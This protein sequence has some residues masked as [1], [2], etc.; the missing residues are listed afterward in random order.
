M[1]IK[2]KFQN[3]EK[4]IDSIFWDRDSYFI[5]FNQYWA[6]IAGSVA[7]KFAENNSSNWGQFDL[8]RTS[9]IKILG[10]NPDN[11]D[12]HCSAPV[13]ILSVNN[14]PYIITGGLFYLIKDK[15]PDEV[16][17]LSQ[18]IVSIALKE[19]REYLKN[20]I[21]TN[22][23]ERIKQI[24]HSVLHS[25][26]TNDLKENTSAFLESSR[27]SN[28]ITNLISETD[29]H[30]LEAL[31]NN[32]AYLVTSN[33]FLQE[34][35][36][37]KNIKNVLLI[38]NLNEMSFESISNNF[39]IINIDGASKGNPGPAAIGVVFYNSNKTILEEYSEFIGI[40][41]NNIA[42]Y[43][44]LVKALEICNEKKYRNIEIKTDS[45]LI[46]KQIN[47]LYK[48]KDPDI[49]ELY[50]KAMSKIKNFNSFKI[51]HI[52]RDENTK[53]DKLANAALRNN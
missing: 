24:G 8:I 2:L 17:N 53:A 23:I 34:T 19:S 15:S 14:F 25:L 45:E 9:V 20:S 38:S 7:Q 29:K 31:L 18:D 26:I 51:S 44:A 16:N 42:E 37:K 35:Y 39:T 21:I 3:T 32:D 43:T 5:D 4:I 52:P 50:E 47:G 28:L 46:A 12:C 40:Q 10:I 36:L 11:G 49:K 48:V 30:S 1:A 33:K 13:K 27:L 6:R 22:N 41:T